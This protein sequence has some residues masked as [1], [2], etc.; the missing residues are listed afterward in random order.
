MHYELVTV[1]RPNDRIWMTQKSRIKEGNQVLSISPS[2]NFQAMLQKEAVQGIN[3]LDQVTQRSHDPETFL[4]FNQVPTAYCTEVYMN[5]D[6]TISLITDGDEIG[7]VSLYPMTR[8]HVKEV[9]YFYPDGTIDFIEEYAADGKLFSTIYYCNDQV[10]EIAFFNDQQQSIL[11][12][13]FYQGAINLVTIRDTATLKVTQKF[14]TTLDFIREQL[15]L[16]LTENDT[17][18]ISYMGLELFALATSNSRNTLY[19]EESPLDG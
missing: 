3:I 4:F 5:E 12:Y 2:P 14:N 11:N 10:Q 8:R 7:K 16:R 9:R 15:A 19:L 17:V 13:Y 6:R 18:G 1:I